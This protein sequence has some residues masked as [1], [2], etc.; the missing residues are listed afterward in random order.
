MAACFVLSDS[1]SDSCFTWAQPLSV[2]M[3]QVRFTASR[4]NTNGHSPQATGTHAHTNHWAVGT[5]TLSL[6]RWGQR[7]E[8]L[9][10]A[11]AQVHRQQV[12]CITWAFS[13]KELLWN[14]KRLVLTGS[15]QSIYVIYIWSCSHCRDGLRRVMYVLWSNGT[16]NLHV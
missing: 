3:V 14:N 15:L 2:C 9:S 8:K 12:W 1:D 13:D 7:A 16:V 4:V 11:F 6:C 10:T 5:N